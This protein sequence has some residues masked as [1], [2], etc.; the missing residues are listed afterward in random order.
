M[1]PRGVDAVGHRQLPSAGKWC[2][3]AASTSRIAKAPSSVRRSLR[4]GSSAC[5]RAAACLPP[6]RHGGL[7]IPQLPYLGGAGPDPKQI[8]LDQATSRLFL[9][10]LGWMRYR[11]SRKVLGEV[12]NVT[13]S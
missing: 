1:P 11:S 6:A 9:P 4:R 2:A 13:V 7:Q 3:A 5:A 12:R 8:K 10:K